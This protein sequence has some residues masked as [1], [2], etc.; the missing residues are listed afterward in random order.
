M[1][2]NT[3]E[4]LLHGIQK[5][6]YDGVTT[7]L[8]D[9]ISDFYI[10]IPVHFQ[11]LDYLNY[12]VKNNVLTANEHAIER[13]AKNKYWKD[14]SVEEFRYIKTYVSARQAYHK[15]FTFD[16]PMKEGLE[17]REISIQLNTSI[18]QHGLFPNQFYFYLTYPKQFLRTSIGSRIN[19]PF[20]RP[21]DCFK[22]KIYVGAMKVFR[23][24]DKSSSRCNTAWERHDEIQNN[25][26]LQEAGC[27]P[28][29]WKISSK[30]PN[31]S[32]P[33]QYLKITNALYKWGEFMPP[34]RSVEQIMKMCT[35]IRSKPCENHFKI[36]IILRLF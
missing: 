15:C 6:D 27:N 3:Y 19:L 17:I 22:F 29:H 34:C 26:I 10:T 21:V 18:F 1:R 35:K 32:S 30:L 14:Y 20:T 36:H 5:I 28:T 2:N 7:G 24:R 16:V 13:M 11:Q 33:K 8:A 4:Q 12:Y 25:H 31:C 9:I 23:R